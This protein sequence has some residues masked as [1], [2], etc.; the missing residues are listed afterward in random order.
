[1]PDLHWNTRLASD[2]NRLIQRLDDSVLLGAHVRRIDSPVSGRFRGEGDE[3]FGARMRSRCVLQRGGYTERAVTHGVRN[4]LA[5][6]CQLR[7]CRAPILI[8][9]DEPAN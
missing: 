7:R 9:E 3:L 8:A 1:M 5:H 6:L 2:P 4:E